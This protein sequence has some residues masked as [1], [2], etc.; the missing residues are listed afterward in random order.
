[1][2]TFVLAGAIALWASL[3]QTNQGKVASSD[4]APPAGI[5]QQSTAAPKAA[6]TKDKRVKAKPSAQ[7][8]AP[9]E[10]SA[11][12]APT[13]PPTHH[14]PPAAQPAPVSEPAP[15]PAITTTS[16]AGKKGRTIAAFWMIAP[17]E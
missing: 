10:P 8:P 13:A 3:G 5:T 12:A 9:T 1:M 7:A 6:Q 11:P 16:P 17:V 2:G 4:L 15:L 14:E